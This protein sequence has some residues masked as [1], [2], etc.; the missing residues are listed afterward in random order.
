VLSG[1]ARFLVDLQ[2]PVET[3]TAIFNAIPYPS[4][5]L[6]PAAVA[7]AQRVLAQLPANAQIAIRDYWLSALGIWLSELGRPAEA[8]P[9]AEEGVTIRRELA[10]ANPDRYRP[11]M[12]QSLGLLAMIYEKLGKAS[13]AVW[14]EAAQVSGLAPQP[15]SD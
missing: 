7:L 12:S 15:G 13:G 9:P 1:V 8:L 5:I 6:T 11:D 3:L 4:I 10:H 2:A 14:T